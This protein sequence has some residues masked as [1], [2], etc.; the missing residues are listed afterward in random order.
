MTKQFIIGL[1][2]VIGA[3]AGGL[4]GRV[5]QENEKQ[6]NSVFNKYG[7]IGAILTIIASLLVSAWLKSEGGLLADCRWHRFR[8][9]RRL[10]NNLVRKK[11]QIKV[12]TLDLQNRKAMVT[13]GPLPQVVA[14]GVRQDMVDTILELL[15]DGKK[16]TCKSLILGEPGSGKTTGI[17][18]LTL[19][20]AIDSGQYFG[21]GGRIPVLAQLGN[22]SDGKLLDFAAA[23][24]QDIGGRNGKILGDGLAK[25]I[26]KKQVVLLCDSLDEALGDRRDVV[27]AQL[28][29]LV[30]SEIYEALPL[31]ITGRTREDPGSGIGEL[32]V[33]EIQDLSDEAIK[34]FIRNYKQPEPDEEK[35]R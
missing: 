8:Y 1:L 10:K 27:R 30:D 5:I 7:L 33:F 2:T 16:R 26:E 28:K 15:N 6:P 14:N 4:L 25:L 20:L 13:T 24:L 32:E 23:S 11:A 18:H 22:Y 29:E 19:K 31:V 12:S 21:F 35:I 3:L 34:A 17:E 9:L